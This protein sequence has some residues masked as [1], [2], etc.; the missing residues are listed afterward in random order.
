MRARPIGTR[1][2]GPVARELREKKFTKD[3]LAGSGSVVAMREPKLKPDAHG[4]RH[5]DMVE[6][7][8]AARKARAGKCW[9]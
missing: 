7:W 1:V 2:F 4:I 8:P 3:H 6:V 9:P 5:G